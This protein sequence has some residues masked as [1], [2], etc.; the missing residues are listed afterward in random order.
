[1]KVILLK[2]VEKLGKR[3]EL[4]NVQSG[5]ARNYLIPQN[6][7]CPAT[8][9]S[10]KWLEVQKEIA[11]KRQETELK[12]LQIVV[13]KIEGKEIN[14]SVKVG[15]KGQLFESI[16]TQKIKDALEEEGFNLTKDQIRLKEPI[17]ELGEFTIEVGFDHNL[18]SFIKV[19]V[20]EKE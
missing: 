1:M 7:A 15:E 14:F 12:D 3:L 2:D 20:T 9:E 13:K 5:Y 10:L 16:T 4:K 19:I 18:E 6:L 11:Q 8:K 17:K